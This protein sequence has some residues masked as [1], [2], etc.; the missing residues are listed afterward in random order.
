MAFSLAINKVYGNAS[1]R[2]LA[3]DDPVQELDALNVYSL[4]ELLRSDFG[5]HYQL[6]LS[7]H[8]EIH[9]DYMAYKFSLDDR[10]VMSIKVQELFF[11]TSVR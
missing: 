8:D 4:I 10:E 9:A 5:S 1:L 6:L 7:T 2:F 3:I 11:P